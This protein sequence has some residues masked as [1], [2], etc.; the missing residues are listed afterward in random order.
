MKHTA[1]V[2]LFIHAQKDWQNNVAF[3]AKMCDMSEYGYTFLGFTKEVS[4]EFD[5]PDD[6]DLTAEEI[7]ALRE[8]QKR[9]QADAQRQ[10]VEIEERIQSMLAIEY[11]PA[12]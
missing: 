1:T 10:V 4:V 6:F 2:E 3:S 12:K 9:I 7:K 8:Q 11:K 5:V